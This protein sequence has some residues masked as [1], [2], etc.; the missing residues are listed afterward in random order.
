MDEESW[1][2]LLFFREAV[3]NRQA[4]HARVCEKLRVRLGEANPEAVMALQDELH[5]ALEKLK[6]DLGKADEAIAEAYW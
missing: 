2:G 6:E 1:D 4:A 5:Q 3:S